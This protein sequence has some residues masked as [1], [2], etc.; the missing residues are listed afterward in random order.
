MRLLRRAHE[1]ALRAGFTLIEVIAA[2]AVFLIVGYA[3]AGSVN[4]A[5]RAQTTVAGTAG[6]NVAVRKATTILRSELKS[7]GDA[8]IGVTTLGDG[9]HELTFQVPIEVAGV[10]GWGAFERRLGPAE[11]LQ[12][13]VGGAVRYTVDIAPNNGTRRLVRVVMDGT[14][15]VRRRDV[16]AQNLA[17]GGGNAPG[18]EVTR[19]GDV[20]RVRITQQRDN[21]GAAR[22]EEFDVRTR[23]E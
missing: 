15:A 11:V 9:N 8:R 5:Q 2:T 20:W 7:T 22:T 3:L 10:P 19:I 16:L 21:G 13:L 17:P 1:R 23:N 18:F 6:R 12:N 14:G 4:L